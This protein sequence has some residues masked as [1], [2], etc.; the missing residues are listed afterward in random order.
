[1]IGTLGTPWLRAYTRDDDTGRV[2]ADLDPLFDADA[3]TVRPN[4][5]AARMAAVIEV[6]PDL[7]GRKEAS[8]PPVV[9]S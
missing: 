4:G 5:L 1:V 6:W 3:R 8:Q 9:T 7:V 2:I